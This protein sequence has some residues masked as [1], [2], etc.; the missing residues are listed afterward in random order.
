MQDAH[1]WLKKTGKQMQDDIE[2]GAAPKVEKLTVREFLGKIRLCQARELD[3][4]PYSKHTGEVEP[5]DPTRF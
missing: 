4:R 2:K 1:D 5:S 3:C